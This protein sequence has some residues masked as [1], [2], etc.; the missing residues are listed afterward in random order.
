M[1]ACDRPLGHNCCDRCDKCIP[2]IMCFL[3]LEEDHQDYGFKISPEKAVERAKSYFAR[4]QTYWT[5]WNT[6]CLKKKMQELLYSNQNVPQNVAW[7]L[8]KDLKKRVKYKYQGTKIKVDWQQF[9]DLAPD[10][11]IVP[12]ISISEL[13]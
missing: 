12:D 3:L 6:Q 7:L 1:K 9:K 4:K 2:T 11:L 8:E 5:Q 13:E 10:D